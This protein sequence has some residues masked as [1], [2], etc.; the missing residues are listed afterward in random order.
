MCEC[1]LPDVF[2]QHLCLCRSFHHTVQCCLQ[3]IWGV[4][5]LHVFVGSSV[6]SSVGRSVGC[7]CHV[8]ADVF[9]SI[10]NGSWMS[11]SC[12]NW[13]FWDVFRQHYH[14]SSKSTWLFWM[15]LVLVAVGVLE[16]LNASTVNVDG[17]CELLELGVA[18]HLCFSVAVA[19][20]C[21]TTEVRM[22][23][24]APWALDG[25]Y[26]NWGQK[27]TQQLTAHAR[28]P[29]NLTRATTHKRPDT[30]RHWC[31]SAALRQACTSVCISSVWISPKST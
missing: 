28:E 8:F 31:V 21:T 22:T 13:L 1:L 20:H 11:T 3:T 4:S 10:L 23:T 19:P 25:A 14:S 27:M 12:K 30:N 24:P 16:L 6:V 17:I 29:T 9:L 18:H 26:A 7:V 15:A 2:A 5:C